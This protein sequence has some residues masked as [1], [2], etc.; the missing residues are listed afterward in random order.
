MDTKRVI[1]VPLPEGM[2]PAAE[3]LES[4]GTLLRAVVELHAG[5]HGWEAVARRLEEEGWTL[6][7]RVGWIVEA[8]RKGEVV[9]QYKIRLPSPSLVV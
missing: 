1:E 9:Q 6:H 3:E 7:T 5:G 8:R 4:L 2:R